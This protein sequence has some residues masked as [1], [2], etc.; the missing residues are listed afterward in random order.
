MNVLLGGCMWVYILVDNE[1]PHSF[2]RVSENF[3]FTNMQ[4]LADRFETFSKADECAEKL[5][6]NG[7]LKDG[8]KLKIEKMYIH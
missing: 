7:K 6:R 3:I 4:S 5:W 2:V 1:N 8:Q